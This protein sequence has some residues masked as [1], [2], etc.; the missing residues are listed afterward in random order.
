MVNNG[1]GFGNSL[2]ILFGRGDGT[3]QSGG[4]LSTGVGPWQA[5]AGD[6][7]GDGY[8]DLA[9]AFEGGFSII[10]GRANGV[11]GARSDYSLPGGARAIAAG[12]FNHDGKIDLVVATNNSLMVLLGNGDGTFQAGQSYPVPTSATLQ[13]ILVGDYNGD[14]KLDLLI[15]EFDGRVFI[16]TGKGDGTFMPPVAIPAGK[17]D[18]GWVTGDFDGDG[19]LDLAASSVLTNAFYVTLNPPLVALY[20]GG[21]QFGAQPVGGAS[22]EAAITVSN[23]S[24]APLK[25]GEITATGPFTVSNGCPTTLAPGAACK[26]S[27]SLIPLAD[28]DASGV[29]TINDNAPGS[30]QYV[31]LHGMGIG[32]AD[33][34]LSSSS[35]N[36]DPQN[37]GTTSAAKIVTLANQGNATLTVG[38]I[39]ASGDFV[40]TNTCPSALAAGSQC[41]ISVTFTPTKAGSRPGTLTITDSAASSPQTVALTGAGVAEPV[42]SL[43]V[44]SL[45]FGNQ[46]VHTTSS[47]QSVGL[48]NTGNAPLEN[49]R[50]SIPRR[51]LW[52][53][54]IVLCPSPQVRIAQSP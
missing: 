49:L 9:V 7:N 40:A 20:P 4:T 42:V 41:T 18:G 13:S 25:F 52:F 12:D 10:P 30:P 54:I 22:P 37:L 2:S 50:V 29:L 23:P 44:S 35:L 38:A 43:S 51:I 15:G 3:F 47:P 27:V 36:F 31:T 6:F 28:G 26:V 11:F 17:A 8:V 45:A 32:G 1:F 21:V 5:V 19:S 48:S 34:S 46:R 24:A 53:P 16:L 39:A 33:A 14:G